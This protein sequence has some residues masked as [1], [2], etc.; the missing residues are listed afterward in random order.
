MK[1]LC[2]GLQFVLLFSCIEGVHL[3]YDGYQFPAWAEGIGWLIAAVIIAFI[4]V[5]AAVTMYQSIGSC[6]ALRYLVRSPASVVA[7]NLRDVVSPSDDWGPALECNR[8]RPHQSVH[9]FH[10]IYL[11]PRW[12]HWPRQMSDSGS[13]VGDHEFHCFVTETSFN[14][15]STADSQ[16]IY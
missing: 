13:A 8:R 15:Q 5:W 11:I 7:L 9:S 3:K 10:W 1:L 14:H 16:S 6:Q 12:L 2:C 4:P